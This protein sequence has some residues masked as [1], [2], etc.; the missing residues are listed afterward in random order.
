[1]ITGHSLHP[2]TDFVTPWLGVC[3][4]FWNPLVYV[5]TLRPF[6]TALTRM[7]SGR[8]TESQ[9][10]SSSGN[11][12]RSKSA[13]GSS[14]IEERGGASSSGS[15]AVK[16]I[17][18]PSVGSCDNSDI[19]DSSGC[20]AV[21]AIQLPS[22]RRHDKS[23]I[24][25]SGFSEMN[26]N[27]VSSRIRIGKGDKFHSG[28]SDIEANELQSMEKCGKGN[29]TVSGFSQLDDKE[30]SSTDSCAKRDSIR[31]AHLSVCEHNPLETMDS[32][33]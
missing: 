16:A 17:E 22:I 14:S 32:V 7:C 10:K 31:I 11:T 15:S 8:P 1:M 20:S 28:S 25:A 3:N 18:L 27:G 9:V 6:Y 5:L 21:K 13:N 2:I 19:I 26:R 4:S 12:P 23:D 33:S 29:R 30:L 24:I